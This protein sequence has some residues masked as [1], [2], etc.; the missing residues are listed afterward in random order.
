MR[1]RKMQKI[2]SVYFTITLILMITIPALI[3]SLPTA[4]A[5]DIPIWLGINVAPSPIGVGQGAYIN[6][7]MTKPTPTASNL[8]GDHYKG[9]TIE[10]IEPDG[11][12]QTL[13]PF[14]A[15]A[16]AGTY[17][18][19]VP[20][21][22]GN[23]TL[24]AFYPGQILTGYN[25][26]FPKNPGINLQLVGSKLL[27]A[28]SQKVTL[29]VQEQQITHYNTAPLPTEY[30]SRPIH[31][32]N[33]DWSNLLGGNWLGLGGWGGGGFAVTGFYDATGNY[34]PYTTAPKTG[35]ILWT[36]PTAFGGQVGGPISADQ[37]S[38]YNSA[39]PLTSYF[40]P[41]IIN[42]VLFYEID[43]AYSYYKQG[44]V[45]V[46]L[47][48]G[49]EIWTKPAGVTGREWLRYG[50]VLS[51]HSIHVYGSSSYLW[52][53]EGTTWSNSRSA[54][55][56]NLTLRIY[57][58]LSCTLLCTIVNARNLNM[59]S[60]VDVNTNEKG[61]LL[62][63]YI[64]NDN[65]ILWNS[66]RAIAYPTGDLSI[67]QRRYVPDGVINWSRGIQWQTPL[68]KTADNKS[69]GLSVAGITPEVIL[70]NYAP[71]QF[72]LASTGYMVSA[73]F[74]A[75]TG[76]LLWGPKN[77]TLPAYEAVSVT[78][79]GAARDGL[80]TVLNKD[81]MEVSGYN[82]NDGERMWGPV[83]LASNA[84]SPMA[85]G[86]AIAY[87]K[88]F[89]WDYPGFIHALDQTT[90]KI[91]WEITPTYTGFDKSSL[92][93]FSTSF[94]DGMLFLGEGSLYNP[95]L[96]PNARMLAINC[97]T[98]ELVWSNLGFSNRMPAAHADGMMVRWNSY[99]KQ[100]YTFGKGP[101]DT[102]VSVSPKITTGGNTIAIE[103]FVTD[104]STG[105]KNPDR[106]ARF[107]DGVP[108]VSDDSMT[109][110]MEYVYQQQPKPT[111]T[112]GVPVILSVLDSNGNYREIGATT[113]DMNG[114]YSYNWTPD[115]EGKYIL[116]A[117]FGGSES[118]WSS[119]SETAFTVD[120]AGPTP[121]PQPEI[122]LPPTEMYIGAAAAAIIVAIVIGFAVTI[123]V[124]RKR[125]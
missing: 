51:W 11:T 90:G 7:L 95:P 81:R 28:E 108:V 19:F 59:I 125:P 39:E 114:F 100:I 47:R 123:L 102:S 67:P 2:K 72:T 71:T 109:P 18:S 41:I 63:Y 124:L 55:S 78:D 96:Y 49:E 22:I 70:L 25:D 20:T 30:W 74:N 92:W 9:V 106:I 93:P 48:T 4:Q 26:N 77:E 98:G 107:P 58:P 110:W 17:T 56:G 37:L 76:A 23:Y 111:N 40:E 83:K 42:G 94:C 21:K 80:Y 38:S 5:S 121:V 12:K 8:F 75:R 104:E 69:I 116:Y 57:D 89:I 52:S 62:G 84:L 53:L 115:I 68:P 31:A 29:V 85:P 6:T 36:K 120:S 60:D 13:G 32:L 65:L 33:F 16:A 122:S 97:T 3:I 112:T 45:A 91:L 79:P 113:S 73:G 101:T 44:W 105:T 46:D 14:T 43:S 15:D 35:H 50:Q 10:I 87:G 119:D 82:L 66:T 34:Q 117:S 24:Q 86:I 64:E 99:D 103:G 118:Y 88:V 61:T 1:K 27:P 54:P